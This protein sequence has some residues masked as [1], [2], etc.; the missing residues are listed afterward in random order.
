MKSE[1]KK[2]RASENVVENVVQEKK[3]PELKA[4][5]AKIEKTT[6]PT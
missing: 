4:E 3:F 2:N 6:I 1:H 5:R